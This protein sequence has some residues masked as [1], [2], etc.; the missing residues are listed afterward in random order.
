MDLRA[1]GRGPSVGDGQQAQSVESGREG[2]D[3]DDRGGDARRDVHVGLGEPPR[4]LPRLETRLLLN[5][6]PDV[7][8]AAPADVQIGEDFP[9]AVQSGSIWQ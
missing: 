3:A 7:T 2:L 5:A 1:A 9:C 6:V 8:V 4:H